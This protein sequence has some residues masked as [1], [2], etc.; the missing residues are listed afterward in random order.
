MQ[1]VAPN[2]PQVCRLA[3]A[4][5]F[6]NLFE[7]SWCI[8]RFS[9]SR[10]WHMIH[11]QRLNPWLFDFGRINLEVKLVLIFFAVIA[12]QV[13]QIL[14][15]SVVRNASNSLLAARPFILSS[16]TH[17]QQPV[18]VNLFFVSNA[19]LTWSSIPCDFLNWLMYTNVVYPKINHPQL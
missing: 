3:H 18:S 6:S 13:P 12:P 7:I 1:T 2:N 14:S 9:S 4:F 19:R 5:F 11:G 17:S 10:W 15:W 16:I 8:Q